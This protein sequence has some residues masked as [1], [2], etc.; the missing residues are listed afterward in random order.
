MESKERLKVS[1]NC[2]ESGGLGSEK[3]K[4]IGE[5]LYMFSEL[6]EEQKLLI[7]LHLNLYD[8]HKNNEI[9]DWLDEFHFFILKK[10]TKI[11]HT[12]NVDYNDIKIGKNM[13]SYNKNNFSP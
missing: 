4:F 9:K 7:K 12:T 11:I 6:K 5:P 3:C 13:I 8:N 10:G 1:E 2:T